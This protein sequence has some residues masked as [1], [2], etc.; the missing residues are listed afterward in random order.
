[1]QL[2]G[3]FISL[4]RSLARIYFPADA[5]SSVSTV[6]HCLRAKNN[7]SL[8][9]GSKNPTTT[10]LSVDEVCYQWQL[11]MSN[12]LTS[13]PR[14]IVSPVHPF[15]SDSQL[16]TVSIPMSFLLDVVSKS[17]SRLSQQLPFSE[18]SVFESESSILT[19]SSSSVRLVNT[20]MRWTKRLS[21]LCSLPT[22]L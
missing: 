17:L 4:P 6:D 18:M 14:S 7:I 19:I 5:N 11:T 1:M 13:R 10:W 2:I 3:S 20:L 9:V 16:K 8:V 12:Q 15:G 21:S 22:S